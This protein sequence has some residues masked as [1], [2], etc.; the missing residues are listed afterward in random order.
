MFS[1]LTEEFK[2]NAVDVVKTGYG[3][4]NPREKVV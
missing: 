2:R 1:S 4:V 3:V